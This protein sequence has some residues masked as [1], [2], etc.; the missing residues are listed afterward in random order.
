MIC[1]NYVREL[2]LETSATHSYPIILASILIDSSMSIVQGDQ[3]G[4][5]ATID[6]CVSV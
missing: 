5:K 1:D 3:L 6:I 2:V 4:P